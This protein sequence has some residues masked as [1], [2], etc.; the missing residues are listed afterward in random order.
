M[1]MGYEISHNI[2][3]I[4]INVIK[5]MSYTIDVYKG[6]YLLVIITQFTIQPL[7]VFYMYNHIQTLATVYCMG[8]HIERNLLLLCISLIIIEMSI[9]H[10]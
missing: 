9:Y 3:N 2:L 10:S 8:K 6:L 5:S 4:S 7:Q 1:Q